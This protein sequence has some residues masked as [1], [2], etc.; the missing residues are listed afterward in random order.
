MSGPLDDVAGAAVK[1]SV[2]ARDG[3][4]PRRECLA[5]ARLIIN[6]IPVKIPSEAFSSPLYTADLYLPTFPG[7]RVLCV[8]QSDQEQRPPPT[9]SSLPQLNYTVLA[10]DETERFAFDSESKCLIVR[11]QLNLSPH[12]NLTLRAIDGTTVSTAMADVSVHDAPLST[13]S[14]TQEKYWANVYENSTKEI[15]VVVLGVKGQPLNKH[16][17][18][19]ILNPNENFEIRTTAGI[20]KTTGK[21]FDRETKDH[22]TLVVQVR[23]LAWSVHAALSINI[24]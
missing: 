9:E 19:S 7:V 23:T 17:L 18:Y 6:V 16:I 14:F 4:S 15:N 1:L 5:P 10:G 12:Y 22:Y 8:G 13:L 2:W 20:I 21:P 11:D 3:G 24:L